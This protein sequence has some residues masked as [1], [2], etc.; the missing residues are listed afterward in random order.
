[1]D[2]KLILYHFPSCPY[3][4]KV[5]KYMESEG[6]ELEMRNI[7]K[8]LD[9]RRELEEVGGIVQVPCLFIDGVPMYESDDII[10][11]LGENYK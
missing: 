8:N 6:I 9:W 1:M 11:W 2:K 3:C 4:V 10:V 5:F 7:R